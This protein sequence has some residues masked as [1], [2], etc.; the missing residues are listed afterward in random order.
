MSFSLGRFI[1]KAGIQLIIPKHRIGVNVI[2]FDNE[3]HV[4]M[5]KHIFHPL[6]PWGLPGGWMDHNETPDRCGLRELK[7]ETGIT[8]ADVYETLAYFRN[9]GPDHLNIIV[10]AQINDSKPSVTIDHSEIIDYKWVTPE[11]V[12]ESITSHTAIGLQRAWRSKGVNFDFIP[13]KMNPSAF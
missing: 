2:C 13:E 7:E 1:L 12:P 9:G 6:S 10:L 3:N 4:L 11:M 5:L 8:N